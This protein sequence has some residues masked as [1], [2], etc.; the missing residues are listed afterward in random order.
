MNWLLFAITYGI[1]MT[2]LYAL[3]CV[4]N[5]KLRKQLSKFS[6][7]LAEKNRRLFL[8][9]FVCNKCKHPIAKGKHHWV[10]DTPQCPHCREA[11]LAQLETEFKKAAD[12]LSASIKQLSE[13]TN[14]SA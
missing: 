7:F 9:Q 8:S 2:V 6:D 11:Y 5:A 10:D 3:E 12:G 13:V 14:D 1:L 4:K